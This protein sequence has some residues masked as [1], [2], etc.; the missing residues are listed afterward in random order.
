[1]SCLCATNDWPDFRLSGSAFGVVDARALWAAV[2]DFHSR[3]KSKVV[4]VMLVVCV[5][6]V[7]DGKTLVVWPHWKWGE[8][9]GSIVRVHGMFVPPLGTARGE[10]AWCKVNLLLLGSIVSLTHVH[11][12]EDNVLVCDLDYQGQT[13]MSHFPEYGYSCP[14]S[15][16]AV[17][18]GV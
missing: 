15:E 9:C 14:L 12:V 5:V 8:S 18:A 16:P 10:L 11:A 13:L 3:L 1:M 4:G 17:A 7:V 2:R 6:E